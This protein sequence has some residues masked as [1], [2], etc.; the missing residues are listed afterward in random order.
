MGGGGG[1]GGGQRL[2]TGV[3]SKSARCQN[4][5][6]DAREITLLWH[7]TEAV[8][9]DDEQLLPLQAL[10]VQRGNGWWSVSVT[11]ATNLFFL[12]FPATS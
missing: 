3:A 12:F 2:W 11:L 10:P 9:V 8:S 7:G 5:L 1:G 4:Q 6:S